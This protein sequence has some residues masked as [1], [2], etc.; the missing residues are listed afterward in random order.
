V[1]CIR[2]LLAFTTLRLPTASLRASAMYEG[3]SS[4]YSGLAVSFSV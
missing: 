3:I 2:S 1:G 4:Q